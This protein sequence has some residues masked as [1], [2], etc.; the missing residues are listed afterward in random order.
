MFNHFM[1]VAADAATSPTIDLSSLDFTPITGA[2]SSAV[3]QVLP[4][5]VG[6]AA[7][8]KVLSFVSSAIYGA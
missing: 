8:R 1:F 6:V 5:I 4:F 2:L 3:P 7:I